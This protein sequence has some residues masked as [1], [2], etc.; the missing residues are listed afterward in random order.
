MVGSSIAKDRFT[1]ELLP[2]YYNPPGLCSEASSYRSDNRK[3]QLPYSFRRKYGW[4]VHSSSVLHSPDTNVLFRSRYS[5]LCVSHLSV[6]SQAH[7][8]HI[9]SEQRSCRPLSPGSVVLTQNS[10]GV[11][12]H[13]KTSF[14]HSLPRRNSIRPYLLR[15]NAR[16]R[17]FKRTFKT[18]LCPRMERSVKLN[19][20]C[21]QLRQMSLAAGDVLSGV[22]NDLR[23]YLAILLVPILSPIIT[24][25][26]Y[27]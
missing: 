6:P 5:S 9:S 17:M 25:S 1:G 10:S 27:S 13:L 19:P 4:Y 8:I 22:G 14:I 12:T 21:S 26:S 18:V 20:R 24:H 15:L 23:T 16:M 2:A 11:S 7:F 3:H